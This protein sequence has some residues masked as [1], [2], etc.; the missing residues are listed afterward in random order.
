METREGTRHGPGLGRR[1][2][3]TLGA[4]A[5]FAVA[6]ARL[7]AQGRARGP[8][9]V[10]VHTHWFPPAFIK[11]RAEAGAAIVTE[12]IPEDSDLTARRRWMDEHGIQTHVLTL[13]GN[14]GWS[15]VSP[16]A[17]NR[18]ATIVN[19]AASEAHQAFPD[20][21]IGSIELPIRDPGFALKELNRVAGRPGMRAVHLPNS[22]EGRD[23]LFEPAFQP[24]LERIEQL[25]Y[26]ILFHPLDG[27]PNIYSRR[28][29]GDVSLT[30]PLGFPFETA[31]VAAKFIVTGT[32]D[33]F[34]KL[35]IVL[36]HSGGA[37]PY[38]AGRLQHARRASNVPPRPIREYLRRFHY[39]T[40]TFYPE[41]L[42]FLI[43]LVGSDRLLIGSDN[44]HGMNVDEPNAMVEDLN[45]PA[46]DRD[47]ILFGNARRLFRL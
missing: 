36:P 38:V 9:S 6:G 21:F 7:W 8:V 28:L 46:A 26:P 5:L 16:E 39:D 13:S 47:R 40:M 29:L 33:R 12:L 1:D 41:T 42:R 34:P 19:D 2:V 43:S 35:D 10:D 27:E 24:I 44:F 31:T 45:L 4:G 32:L 23:Y 22:I 18:I 15:F 30:N 20:R 17:G 3:M 37:F 25:G 14:M 11:A